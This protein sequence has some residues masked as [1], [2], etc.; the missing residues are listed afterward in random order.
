M[1]GLR[2]L[3]VCVA[4]SASA[5]AVS[6]SQAQIVDINDVGG[7]AVYQN[8]VDTIEGEL[9]SNPHQCLSDGER[10][11]MLT[12][13]AAVFSELRKQLNSATQE[14]KAQRVSR[15]AYRAANAHVAIARDILE[16]LRDRVLKYPRCP[17]P[18]TPPHGPRPL[19]PSRWLTSNPFQFNVG[20]E[21]GWTALR[22]P[23][24]ETQLKADGG[25][26]GATFGARWNGMNNSFVGLQ[27]TL[28]FPFV[29]QSGSEG[30]SFSSATTSKLQNLAT[31]DV[32]I[33]RTL[34]AQ[35]VLGFI[36]YNGF[37]GVAAG[38]VKVT[39]SDLSQTHTLF[40]PTAGVGASVNVSPHVKVFTEARYFRLLDRS[41]Q[42]S[43][44]G[45]GTQVG[46]S[47][48]VAT[49]GVKF[50]LGPP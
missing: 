3:G 29:T 34:A 36:E 24:E 21:G 41:F 14:Y 16:R 43:P 38:N 45:P 49:V 25:L 31:A 17:L 35:G 13:I 32:V 50:E 39:Q 47:G 2:I 30:P 48:V 46:Q 28:L 19:P 5:F 40:G 18:S 20:I 6:T 27:G 1:R 9:K 37:M 26:A 23:M 8:V 7:P 15:G 10:S 11:E 44:T 42:L 4:V 22:T 33:G 12:R